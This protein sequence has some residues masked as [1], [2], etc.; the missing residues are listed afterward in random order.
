[1]SRVSTNSGEVHLLIAE[2]A[3]GN[4][5]HMLHDDNDLSVLPNTIMT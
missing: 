4:K 5:L 2:I 3:I 1:V